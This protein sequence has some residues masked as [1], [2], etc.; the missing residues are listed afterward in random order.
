MC[1]KKKIAKEENTKK[2]NVLG[3]Q[4]AQKKLQE[5]NS[6]NNNRFFFKKETPSI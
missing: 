6:N 2:I 4:T 5:N 1:E 3:K